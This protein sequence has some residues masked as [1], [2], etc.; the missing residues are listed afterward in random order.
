MLAAADPDVI[1]LVLAILSLVVSVVV[2]SVQV[3]NFRRDRVNVRV[4]V[5]GKRKFWQIFWVHV[6]PVMWL[7]VRVVNKG[8]APTSILSSW[9]EIDSKKRPG[10]RSIDKSDVSTYDEPE[11]PF[12]LDL[13]ALSTREW[14]T[15]SRSWDAEEHGTRTYRVRYCVRL[16]NDKRVRSPC[17]LVITVGEEGSN[18]EPRALDRAAFPRLW[19]P[20]R[21]ILRTKRATERHRLRF[22]AEHGERRGRGRWE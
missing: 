20:L 21:E 11:S 1:A 22:T 14:T 8:R 4:R 17:I 5:G 9:W 6:A 2:A 15:R 19:R 16:G 13:P 3:L 18:P 10:L 7:P 12:P